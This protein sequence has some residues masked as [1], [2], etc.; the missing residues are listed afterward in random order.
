[1]A[2]GTRKS[3]AGYI[4]FIPG[5]QIQIAPMLGKIPKSFL[6]KVDMLVCKPSLFSGDGFH[7]FNK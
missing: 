7:R 1:M 4:D 2:L 3:I 5:F 6:G